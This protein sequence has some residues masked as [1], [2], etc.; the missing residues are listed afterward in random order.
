MRPPVFFHGD[1]LYP[2]RR[3]WKRVLLSCSL[4]E[5][6]TVILGLDRTGDIPGSAAP[7][8]WF[9]FLKTGNM[10]P[11]LGICDHNRRD[12]YGLAALFNALVSIAANPQKGLKTYRGDMEQTAIHWRKQFRYQ[13]KSGSFHPYTNA[14]VTAM[15][16]T[17]FRLLWDA[18]EQGYPQAA[19]LAALDMFSRHW[20]KDGRAYLLALTGESGNDRFPDCPSKI[21][22]SAYRALAIDAEYR[23]HD[24]EQ[25]LYYTEQALTLEGIR[26]SLIKDFSRRRDRLMLSD[27][28]NR[29]QEHD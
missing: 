1:L 13:S 16:E 3:L 26:A 12:I 9:S 14:E 8:I 15:R 28:K 29:E 17:V 7:D 2:A 19:L 6:E 24:N 4:G 23:L 5:I 21:K 10:E 18:A 22:A 20:N 25:A 11:L 27:I